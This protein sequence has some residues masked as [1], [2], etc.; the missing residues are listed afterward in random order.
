MIDDLAVV[1]LDY[2]L[3]T[4]KPEIIDFNEVLKGVKSDLDELLTETD[5]TVEADFEVPEILYHREHLRILF[6]E[7]I[8]NSI[9][10]CPGNRAPRIEIRSYRD[11]GRVMLYVADNACGIDLEKHRKDI[12]KMYKPLGKEE[13]GSKGIGLFR[14]KNIVEINGGK[15]ELSSDPGSGTQFTIEL[16]R[17]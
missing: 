17:E 14:L 7:L 4:E 1:F 2:R 9:K 13:E 12:F 16:G 3:L 6:S 11:N 15:V 8:S 10:F 5:T